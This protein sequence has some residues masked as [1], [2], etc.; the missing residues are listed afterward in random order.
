[1]IRSLGGWREVRRYGLKGQDHIKS[2]ER[3]LGESNFVNDV[4]S[5]ANEKFEHKYEL[6]R[7]GYDLNRIASRVA[8]IYDIGLDEIFLKGKQQKRVQA[9]S[10]LCYWAVRELGI[11][12]TEL[13]RRLGISVPGVGYS[14]ERGEI[15]ARKNN[16][17]LIE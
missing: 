5:Q 2:D 12:L 15:I 11:S 4:L 1:M 8:E 13:A 10:L 7:L 14:V 9:R 6:K 16:Y 3:I 17:R